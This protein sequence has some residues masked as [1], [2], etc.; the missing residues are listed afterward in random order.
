MELDRN[1]GDFSLE[2]IMKEF[3]DEPEEAATEEVAPEEDVRVWDGNLPEEAYQPPMDFSDTVRLDDIARVLQEMEQEQPQEQMEETVRFQLDDTVQFSLPEVDDEVFEEYMPEPPVEKVEPF[4]QDWEPEYDQPINDYVPPEPIPFRP[5]SR[6]HELKKKLVEGPERRYYQLTEIGLGKLQIAIFLSLIISALA[7]C[8]TAMYAMGMVPGNRLR[9]LVFFQFFALLMSALLGSYQ[10][11]AGFTGLLRRRFS[12][13]TLLLFSFVACLADGILCLK[14]VHV[15]CCA[16]FSLHVTMS[17]WS[18]YQKR[19]A[20]ISQMDTM[21]KATRLDSIVAVPDG[22]EGRQ[23]FVTGEG[24]VEDFM[25]TYNAPS[26]EEKTLS[27]YGIVA[28]FVSL[29]SGI[30]A[31]AL[32]GAYMGVQVFCASLLVAVPAT[33]FITLS[34]PMAILQRRLRKHGT[35]ICGWQGVRQLSRDGI[36]PL[37]DTDVF[38]IGSAKLNGVKFY[39]DRDPDEVVS[40]AVSLIA[41]G[42]G[43]EPLFNQL[44][45]SRNGYRYTIDTLRGYPGGGI[46]GEI[47]GEAVLA[48]SLSFMQTMGVDMPQG[49]RVSQAVYVAIDGSLCGVF[50]I[51]YSKVKSAAV[52]LTTLCAYRGLTPMMTGGDFMLTESFIRNKFGVNTRRMAFPSREVREKL[53]ALEPDP[54]LPALALTTRDGLAST[55]YAVTGARALQTAS[56][57]GVI[58]HMLGGIIGLAMMAALAVIGA[59]EL[60]TP[61]NVL[62]YE[63]IWMVPGLLITE[64]TRSV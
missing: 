64:W 15:P 16:A 40:Y 59:Q 2:E 43:L 1:T 14:E 35:V 49:T 39:G 38:P 36:Y 58:I 20:E 41:A 29:G 22:F 30:L 44:L 42:G 57:L 37:K 53:T 17:L 52:G 51:T 6:L 24:Q 61:A 7:A 19:S 62:L 27:L 47:N 28:L 10:M 34:R 4:S 12:L 63:L 32:H 8:S 25:D 9:F 33:S 45:E 50:A 13:D 3:G 18:A 31:G 21:R 56:I 26:A 23:V 60:L 48:G 54:E 5:R 55:A 46:G 11:M